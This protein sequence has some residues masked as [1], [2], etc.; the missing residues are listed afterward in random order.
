MGRVRMLL[1][2]GITPYLVFD[3]DRLPSKAI[4]EQE[5][6]SRREES[7]KVGLQ[8]YHAGRKAE[9]YRELQN[10][11]DITPTMA[12]QLIG[13]LKRENI[14][15]LVAPYE[16]DAQLT[17]LESK[18][19][20]DAI[21]S[22]DSDLLVFGAKRLISKLDKHG[23]CIEINRANFTTCKEV[24][25]IGWTDADFRTMCILSGC[26]Y[27]RN[28]PKIGLKTAHRYVR[29]YR[30]VDRVVRAIQLENK[31]PVPKDYLEQ[32]RCAE[33]TFLHHRVFCPEA[34]QL[35]FLH[36]LPSHLAEKDLSFLGDDLEPDVAIG[37]AS[38]DLDPMTKRS[39]EIPIIRSPKRSPKRSAKRSTFSRRTTLPPE[40][41]KP[42]K[43]Q[44]SATSLTNRRTPLGE[45]DPNSLTPL[46]E[47]QRRLIGRNEGRS[48]STNVTPLSQHENPRSVP[49]SSPRS[50]SM[51]MLTPASSSLQQ[52]RGLPHGERSTGYR[53]PARR[54]KRQRLCADADEEDDVKEDGYE[55]ISG[56]GGTVMKSRF[57]STP[58]A[59]PVLNEL[60]SSRKARGKKSRRS[61][62]GVYSDAHINDA[63]SPSASNATTGKKD[64]LEADKGVPETPPRA[65]S[66]PLDSS[67]KRIP[68]SPIAATK[69]TTSLTSPTNSTNFSGNVDEGYY[70]EK[71]NKALKDHISKQNA[72]LREK[73]SFQPDPS[74]THSSSQSPVKTVAKSTGVSSPPTA[75]TVSISPDDNPEEFHATLKH[76]VSRQNLKL[77]EKYAYT[78]EPSASGC[79]PVLH[80]SPSMTPSHHDSHSSL[81]EGVKNDIKYP[82]LPNIPDL[83]YFRPLSPKKFTA[84]G[85]SIIEYPKLPSIHP[86]KS[87]SSALAAAGP[88][89]PQH[90][91]QPL[92][93]TRPL[94]SGL[95]RIK[96]SMLSRSQSLTPLP[97]NSRTSFRSPVYSPSNHSLSKPPMS[98][99]FCNRS[100][101]AHL[102]DSSTDTVCAQAACPS[103]VSAPLA[104]GFKGS[105][106][107]L[108]PGYPSDSEED[109]SE[110]WTDYG[111]AV[112]EEL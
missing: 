12:R 20:I 101:S 59:G 74:A 112:A 45:L 35:V 70:S 9:A 79:K 16:A 51:S 60:D 71:F 44:S 107:L 21:I 13:E 94:S 102:G 25:F 55:S 30:N 63:S 104:F 83:K 18:G 105:E 75:A 54:N 100:Q 61:D 85:T 90:I 67:V 46:S 52:E 26:D 68:E 98:N 4:T 3:G 66:K 6:V 31:T 81:D 32:F 87:S 53:P 40:L 110:A 48:W 29:R 34:K 92:S 47:S 8:L 77:Q 109:V 39:I 103:P 17:Y 56:V 15:Y 82:E 97:A 78:P 33:H 5:R 72:S 19:I 37:V 91:K 14:P 96:Q 95:E 86:M 42:L 57:F 84:T 28:I 65:I 49:S 50:V 7:R 80:S 22:E 106:D 62:F 73:Y 10:A 88:L 27:L 24:S 108:G 76:H 99:H 58:K 69:A 2:F 111:H 41:L 64:E 11:I 93:K 1:H 23:D 89:P 36:P 43:H 38:G